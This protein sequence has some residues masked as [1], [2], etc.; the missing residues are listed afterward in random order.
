MMMKLGGN[1]NIFGV[2]MYCAK[3][4]DVGL[5]AAQQFSQSAGCGYLT[6]NLEEKR[7]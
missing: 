1:K 5:I 2:L 3:Y 4:F 6:Y 7:Y